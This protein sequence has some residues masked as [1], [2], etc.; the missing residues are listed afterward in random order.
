MKEFTPKLTINWDR[1]V[2]NEEQQNLAR[3]IPEARRKLDFAAWR[4]AET[5]APITMSYDDLDHE[6]LKPFAVDW[7]LMGIIDHALT[8]GEHL[9]AKQGVIFEGG[10]TV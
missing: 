4:M 5:G 7:D 3:D 2:A 10:E 8:K 6:T 9:L 1:P